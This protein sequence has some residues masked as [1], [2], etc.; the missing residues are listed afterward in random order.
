MVSIVY[1]RILLVNLII[2]LSLNSCSTV[3]KVQEDDGWFPSPSQSED[4]INWEY[5]K[6]NLLDSQDGS[7][8]PNAKATIFK[9]KF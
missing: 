4:N 1:M 8:D 2:L 7:E 6:Y 9:N 5:N 3:S